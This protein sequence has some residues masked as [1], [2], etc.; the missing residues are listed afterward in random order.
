MDKANC[1]PTRKWNATGIHLESGK[2]YHIEA[3]ALPD[4][5]G[6]AYSD[7]GL[8]CTPDGA[9]TLIGKMFDWL[10]RDARGPLNLIRLIRRDR[11][12]HLRVLSDRFGKK[13]HFLTVIGSI[14][15]PSEADLE[16]SAFVIGSACDLVAYATG[17]LF[18][19]SNDWP[20]DDSLPDKDQPYLNNTGRI[21]LSVSEGGK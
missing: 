6:R 3:H 2:D 12:K 9:S 14:G 21:E 19:F 1:D 5:W 8:P 18:A 20:G 10:A 15:Q 13:A 11:V 17:E 4:Q 16:R 7:Q